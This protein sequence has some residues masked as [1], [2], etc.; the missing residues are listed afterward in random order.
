MD[1]LTLSQ[2]KLITEEL[3]ARIVAIYD[4]RKDEPSWFDLPQKSIDDLMELNDEFREYQCRELT[5]I[6]K[7]RERNPDPQ[8]PKD[9]RKADCGLYFVTVSP[10]ETANLS[11]F[12]AATHRFVSL[13]VVKEA[14]YVFEQRGT[15]EEEMGKG[16]HTHMLCF[17]DAKPSAFIK[18]LNRIFKPFFQ[19]DI[20]PAVLEKL[21]KVENAK[22]TEKDTVNKILRYMRGEKRPKIGKDKATKVS[23]DKMWRQSHNLREEYHVDEID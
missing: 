18:E 14:Y 9:K 3:H 1:R 23:V 17:R 15:T 4:A 13:K 22:N 10:P 6:G 11:Q 20:S 8:V 12:I 21:I 7:Q 5:L 2:L 19:K 16:F